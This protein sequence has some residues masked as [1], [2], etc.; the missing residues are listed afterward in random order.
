MSNKIWKIIRFIL[1]V[2]IQKSACR[3]DCIS[4]IFAFWVFWPS[5]PSRKEGFEEAKRTRNKAA[6]AECEKNARSGS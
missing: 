4:M 1:V 2:W 6:F 5:I 3:F